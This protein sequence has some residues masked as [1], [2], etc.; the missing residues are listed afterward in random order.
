MLV[1][2]DWRITEGLLHDV[3]E[4]RASDEPS[5]PPSRGDVACCVNRCASTREAEL[6]KL[7]ADGQLAHPKS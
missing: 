1:E 4:S 6:G 7:V 2:P 3:V 5:T